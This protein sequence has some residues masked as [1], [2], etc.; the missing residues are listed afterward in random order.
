[1]ARRRLVLS[2]AGEWGLQKR[3]SP[4]IPLSLSS[5]RETNFSRHRSQGERELRA[6]T[7]LPTFLWEK[8]PVS[9]FPFCDSALSMLRSTY[10]SCPNI[11]NRTKQ[12]ESSSDYIL[13]EVSSF[14]LILVGRSRSAQ[15]FLLFFS[16]SGEKKRT[17]NVTIVVFSEQKIWHNI[18][19]SSKLA[20]KARQNSLFSPPSPTPRC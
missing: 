6:T 3:P 15:M 12:P 18:F 9:Q 16:F 19:F 1:M 17:T 7:N 14:V 20:E 4:T 8:P 11:D 10:F 13:F 2:L 5:H